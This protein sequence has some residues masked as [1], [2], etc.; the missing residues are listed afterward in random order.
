MQVENE[1]AT[2]TSPGEP[3]SPLNLSKEPIIKG[4]F[5][6][7]F[8]TEK[9]PYDEPTPIFVGDSLKIFVQKVGFMR[10]KK[11]I[12]EDHQFLVKVESLNDKPPLLSSI[13]SVLEKS[14]EQMLDN[15]RTFY[16]AEDQNLVYITIH[17]S[18]MDSAMNSA[19]FEI[20]NT[21]N[22]IIL[23]HVL[24][25]FNR[26][27]RSNA[28]LR[29]E[30]D[31]SVYFRVLSRAHVNDSSN[32]RGAIVREKFC[33]N[34]KHKF[35]C[36]SDNGSC[37][38]KGCFEIPIGYSQKPNAFKDKCLL[39]HVILGYYCFAET[40]KLPT[41][42]NI[43]FKQ[44]LKIN[45]KSKTIQNKA[46]NLLESIIFDL[47]TKLNLSPTGPYTFDELVPVLSNHYNCQ[48]HVINGIE[49]RQINILSYPEVFDNSLHQIYL[50][51]TLSNHV[52]LISNLKTFFNQNKKICFE[53]K[54]SFSK[55]HYHVCQ[56]KDMCHF[57][58]SF[59]AD[60]N[61][62]DIP[63]IRFCDRQITTELLAP[64][65]ICNKCEMVFVSKKCY[66]L[67]KPIC[68]S[69]WHCQLCSRTFYISSQSTQQIKAN[70]VC[71]ITTKCKYCREEYASDDYH[72]C[73]IPKIKGDKYWP[74][75]VFFHF[76]FQNL[77][78]SNCLQCF[79]L[80]KEYCDKNHIE[81]NDFRKHKLFGT[82]LCPVHAVKTTSNH[83]PN[84]CVLFRETARG[85]FKQYTLCDDNL[86]SDEEITKMKVDCDL[87][88]TYSD[89]SVEMPYQNV[90]LGGRKR[91]RT[92]DLTFK[93][94][95]LKQKQKK[96]MLEK[97]L[98]LVTQKD[99][100][101]SVY[102]SHQA[103]IVNLPS[104]LEMF[105]TIGLQPNIIQKSSFL[106]S[107]EIEIL[108]IK[109]LNGS[110]FFTGSIEEICNQFEIPFTPSY[111]P[112]HFN[113]EENY[114]YFGEYPDVKDYILFTDSKM[115]KDMKEQY[116]K[117]NNLQFQMF[118]FK[119]ELILY[120]TSQCRTFTF[121]CLKFL[122]ETIDF[123]VQLQ[124]HLNISSQKLI[125][126]FGPKSSSI[127]AFS[128]NQFAF[129]FLQDYNL[130]ATK[131]DYTGGC[132]NVSSL[133]YEFA[134]C[135]EYLFKEL[136]YKHAFNC[137]NGQ[138]SFGVIKAD[139]YSPIN[140]IVYNFHGCAYHY[141][142]SCDVLSK[143]KKNSN[144]EP[145]NHLK[146]PYSTLKLRDEKIKEMLL[147]KFG[148]QVKEYKVMKE[149]EWKKQ[150]KDEPFWD[151]FNSDSN[152]IKNRPKHRLIPRICIRSGFLE[153]YILRWLQTDFPNE[154]FYHSDCNGL[155][156]HICLTNDFPVGKYEVL[157]TND[158]V[159]K[160]TFDLGQHF[161][162]GQPLSGSA[163]HVRILAPTNLKKPFLSFRSTKEHNFMSLC[164]SCIEK[165]LDDIDKPVTK[166]LHRVDHARYFESC[167][168]ITELDKAVSLGYIILEWFEIH[169][170]SQKAPLLKNYVSIL[171]ALKLQ[172][173]G[174]DP[175]LTFEEKQLY[176]DKINQRL[177]VPE[178]FK[179][180]PNNICENLGKK[181]FYKSMLN[182]YLGK[183]IQNTQHSSF[184][185]VQ[186]QYE[187]EQYCF[188]VKNEIVGIYPFSEDLIQVEFKPS[189]FNIKPSKKA[190]LY[191][192]AEIIAK[193]RVHIYNCIE[194][195]EAANARI[196]FVDTDGIG[197]SLDNATQNPLIFTNCTGDFK[198]VQT[199]IQSFHA[200]GNRNYTIGY[201]DSSNILKYDYKVKGVTL[202]SQHVSNCMT[203]NL[204][205]NFLDKH[206][207]R[208]FDQI[209][210]PQ[211][212]RKVDNT[213][214]KSTLS[215]H[216]IKF[217][218]NLFVKRYIKPDLEVQ[219]Y[220]TFPY[221][222]KN[223]E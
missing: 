98:L 138:K 39:V 206:F 123:Q 40:H 132:R 54:K 85:H 178:N 115:D 212:K 116:Y 82:V 220:E 31:F 97:F 48:I 171:S 94:D 112:E 154:S 90:N 140:K 199:N 2:P 162:N 52:I 51:S 198:A 75:L 88:Y 163:A 89:S 53:C 58:K 169:F 124:A 32:R 195:L 156:P 186:T 68:Y 128:Y 205:Q 201:L 47:I 102:I 83:K 91:V 27:I 137:A 60:P 35:G 211:V 6:Q 24:G 111:F 127:S 12:L 3:S 106:H 150:K 118:H 122:K 17:Q 110:A 135:Y 131:F 136:D 114:N 10:Q 117:D 96:S 26:F 142:D 15:L 79:N 22:D 99:W 41:E 200:L 179:I 139:L 16:K 222:F 63:A 43:T 18:E 168:M 7:D 185:F 113:C 174:C 56:S 203:P 38:R 101:N 67:H 149:C 105:L 57:C 65:L 216:T 170:F 93:L 25:M 218:N 50:L 1:D 13:L 129:F 64:P 208:E 175:N 80:K 217:T 182:N 84:A 189:C 155:Y 109:F 219:T 29:L 61:T 36:A 134:C 23:S 160:I 95:L 81:F 74:N 164:R 202:T 20:S 21:S 28:S 133:E 210:L 70:H 204:Y 87:H 144:G 55:N 214:K 145:I 153:T 213:N 190:N 76:A 107:I 183:F 30:K 120:L 62:I 59:Y 34:K 181:Q 146:I 108:K 172:N 166:C 196:F 14:L 130:F 73:A 72:L 86:L 5:V 37:K 126:P 187:L 192:G 158:L 121:A 191:I 11:F 151:C 69:R 125:H 188:N 223:D 207:M 78:S 221:G 46:G 194:I 159:D 197:Y 161:Y 71:G 152:F 119:N 42:S 143:A 45:N 193:A 184:K 49:Q 4:K 9:F 215:M 100:E 77:N 180:T 167:W 177:D 8:T 19:A 176:C 209:Y 66:D 141:C 103:Q 104:L 33:K 147:G 92:E 157:L 165:N 44:L 173:T 148:H